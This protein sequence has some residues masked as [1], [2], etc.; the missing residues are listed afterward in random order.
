MFKRKE[1]VE[2]QIYK[3][4]NNNYVIAQEKMGMRIQKSNYVV[5]FNTVS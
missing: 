1:I 4:K 3:K 5:L 2:T